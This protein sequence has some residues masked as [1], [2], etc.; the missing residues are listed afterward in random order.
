MPAIEVPCS[1]YKFRSIV[2][3]S[4]DGVVLADKTGTFIEWNSS[5]ERLTGLKRSEVVGK[6]A[7]D[8]LF[9]LLP[10]EYQSAQL[11]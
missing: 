5:M 6:P 4:A 3:Q 2:E 7:A 9:S 11:L 8:I 10:P 1:E